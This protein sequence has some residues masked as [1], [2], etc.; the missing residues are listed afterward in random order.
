MSDTVMSEVRE[1]YVQK[2]ADMLKPLQSRLSELEQNLDSIKD[3]H[4]GK[5]KARLD[6]LSEI[7]KTKEDIE[8]TEKNLEYSKTIPINRSNK[9]PANI[10]DHNIWNDCWYDEER[11]AFVTFNKYFEES[12]NARIRDIQIQYDKQMGSTS[13]IIIPEN[14]IQFR[15]SYPAMLQKDSKQ[16]DTWFLLPTITDNMLTKDMVKARAKPESDQ[17]AIL[18]ETESEQWITVGTDGFSLSERENEIC[19]ELG[20]FPSVPIEELKSIYGRN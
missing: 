20:I 1:K 12:T 10:P 5:Q 9:V 16:R 13:G 14:K 18:Y 15:F 19:D 6:V 11:K 7:N 4:P 3:D 2:F 17:N 8:N